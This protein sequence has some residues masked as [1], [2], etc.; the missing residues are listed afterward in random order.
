VHTHPPTHPPTHPHTHT[1]TGGVQFRRLRAARRPGAPAASATRARARTHARTHRC[2]HGSRR[3]HGAGVRHACLRASPFDCH[4]SRP[5]HA[6]APRPAATPAL[7]GGGR[8]SLC[9]AGSTSRCRAPA[10]RYPS[11]PPPLPSRRLPGSL[12]LSL[13]LSL[14]REIDGDTHTHTLT[15]TRVRHACTIT[16]LVSISACEP[17]PPLN[18][19]P[20]ECLPAT[21]TRSMQ[22][23]PTRPSRVRQSTGPR[24]RDGAGRTAQRPSQ[25]VRRGAGETRCSCIQGSRTVTA[26]ASRH[27]R[28]G[29]VAPEAPPKRQRAGQSKGGG[30][31][32]GGAGGAAARR[33]PLRVYHR[34]PPLPLLQGP[35]ALPSLAAIP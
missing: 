1:R 2:S 14:S 20:P 21:E 34:R 3:A 32:A 4:V 17:R 30:A 25:A 7:T 26:P 8:W 35:V 28:A 13:S 29:V 6:T 15:L 9:A 12:S 11:P 5:V 31:G 24:H 23:Q 19:S 16:C 27:G 22:V 10:S 18:A 33:R